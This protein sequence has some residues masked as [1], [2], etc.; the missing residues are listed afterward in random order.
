MGK[1]RSNFIQEQKIN[2]RLI[3]KAESNMN[4]N[5]NKRTKR[6]EKIKA[7]YNDTQDTMLNSILNDSGLDLTSIPKN[8]RIL[9]YELLKKNIVNKYH[10]YDQYIKDHRHDE[11]INEYYE[12]QK[13][14]LD[15]LEQ[16]NWIYDWTKPLKDEYRFYSE[17]ET[18][19]SR[20]KNA[21]EKLKKTEKK[22][23]SI[24]DIPEIIE[25][26]NDYICYLKDDFYKFCKFIIENDLDKYYIYI[27][28][29]I[30]N[31][32]TLV[33]ED[34]IKD[35]MVKSYTLLNEPLNK[36]EECEN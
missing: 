22:F 16:I 28:N 29:T 21:E 12:A 25:V 8:S 17:G 24:L 23:D 13:I 10:Q 36:T 5:I 20:L 15:S 3:S 14:C 30:K 6:M 33:T 32:K 19:E 9:I 31:L 2:Q 18:M 1:K 35:F 34:P 4:H 11:N 27:S 7:D 26:Y